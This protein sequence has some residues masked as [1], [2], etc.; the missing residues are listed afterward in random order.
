MQNL[1]ARGSNLIVRVGNAADIVPAVAAALQGAAVPSGPSSSTATSGG[2]AQPATQGQLTGVYTMEEVCDEELQIEAAV[3]RGLSRLPG[4]PPLRRYWSGTMYGLNEL[5]FRV[6]PSAGGG[7]S[8][9]PNVYSSFRRKVEERCKVGK[10]L[11][12][13]SLKPHLLPAAPAAPAP[14]SEGGAVP[15][16]GP[17]FALAPSG[18]VAR[19]AN[20]G[21]GRLPSLWALGA[22]DLRPFY[23]SL[24]IAHPPDTALG[25]WEPG[26]PPASETAGPHAGTLTDE[27][28]LPTGPTGGL[29]SHGDVRGVLGA[30]S[31]G[32]TTATSTG[33]RG[34]ETA[35][36]ARLKEYLWDSDCLKTYKE[37]RNGML[38]GNYSSKF[39]P[40]LAHGCLSPRTVVAE[41]SRYE[42][43]R[44]ANDS[45][46]WLLFELIWRD[47][48]RFYAL[49]HGT[50]L[51]QLWGPR[52][53]P[54]DGSKL[55]RTDA[56]FMQAWSLGTTGYP[57]V[58]ANMRELLAT[59]FQSN[60][61]RQNVASFFVKD[62]DMDWR[63]GGE[64]FEGLLLD[65]DAGSN[66]GN[67]TYVAGVGADPR[68]DRYFLIPKQS[69][70]YDRQGEY[71][72]HWLPELAHAPVDALHEPYARMPKDMVS[73]PGARYPSC[74]V[75]LM[76]HRQPRGGGGGGGGGKHHGGGEGHKGHAGG[77]SAS[78]GG[79]SGGRGGRYS[80][81]NGVHP[82]HGRVQHL[83]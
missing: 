15:A 22:A 66:W 75:Q 16:D 17:Q 20:V 2:S 11:P 31:P 57:F 30:K 82:K 67:W 10:A 51:F 1:Q 37:T 29:P 3:C 24:G 54:D 64:W 69:R 23:H 33:F 27:Q 62:L 12:V 9:L 73:G 79:S 36:L 6:K 7:P 80:K 35:A 61:G 42:K 13:P 43:E 19:G 72:R 44:V 41:V 55:W 49:A 26:T 78:G 81:G 28:V 65:H 45:T 34:G 59:G 77:G 21:L 46:Y 52:N 60:R 56:R 68:E 18:C 38:G 8:E 83:G 39:S 4:K 14:S 32:N 50:R 76:A 48:F 58:D 25:I 70:D 47:Y 53:S 40:W 5:P 71:M 74:V 63:L